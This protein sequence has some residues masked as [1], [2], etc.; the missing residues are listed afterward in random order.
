MIKS[1]GIQLWTVRDKMEDAAAIKDTF[2]KLKAMGYDEVQTA[3]CQI[4]YAEF[5]ALAKETGLKIVG[6]HDNFDL[7]K[8]DIKQSIANH[9]LLDTTNM[10]IGGRGYETEEDVINFIKDANKIAD[11]IYD[12]GFKFTYHNHSHEFI[13]FNGKTIMDMLVE[14]LSPEKVSFVLD[15]YWVQ[16]AG[17]DVCSW[18]KKLAGRI[19]ILHL[20]DMG[21]KKDE[22]GRAI[23]YITEMGNG[24]INFKDII[25]AA[26]ETGVKYF[27]VE[28]DG[29]Y[30]ADSM[31]SAKA[32]VDYIKENFMK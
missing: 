6:T 2:T 24:N 14:G 15:T 23:P 31:A 19:D 13:K 8:T 5:G 16:H 4:P 28:Q 18:I 25:D 26:N 20:K 12:E 3:G 11:E 21:V 1:L 30:A 10:G 9:R 17:G 22:E 7:M 27:C 29:N 32:S